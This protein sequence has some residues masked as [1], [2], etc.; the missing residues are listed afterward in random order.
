MFKVN[1]QEI[2]ITLPPLMLS[3]QV[4][5]STT[6]GARL[7][8]IREQCEGVQLKTNPTQPHQLT[9]S[10]PPEALEKAK[11]LIDSM[12]AKMLEMCSDVCHHSSV[13]YSHVR[14]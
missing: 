11:L 6:P 1:I 9:I 13:S 5:N 3:K 4:G 2:T 10:G 12:C 8:S 7:R 14:F